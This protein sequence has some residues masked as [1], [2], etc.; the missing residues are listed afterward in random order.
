MPPKAPT[1]AEWVPGI[2][3]ELVGQAMVQVEAVVEMVEAAVA[4]GMVGTR[5]V[6]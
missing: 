1:R 4:V 2:R 3:A 6:V 5:V